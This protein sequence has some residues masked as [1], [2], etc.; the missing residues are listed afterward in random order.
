MLTLIAARAKNGAIG[1]DGDIPWHAPED[2]ALFKRETLG[3]AVIMGR[4]TWNSLPV[5][6]L[7]NRLNIIVT[8]QQIEG[9]MT[10]R[11]PVEAVERAYAEG[12]PRVYGIGGQ[13]IY[14]ALLPHADRLMLTEVDLVVEDAD[15]FFPAFDAAHWH[16]L[17][18]TPL[19]DDAPRCTLVE[20]VRRFAAK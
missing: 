4:K 14:D 15:A 2:L 5:R 16:V 13:G 20:R 8:S 9:Q 18:E 11:D 17:R 6:P 12:I 1:K 10:A 19:R 3:G 7:G